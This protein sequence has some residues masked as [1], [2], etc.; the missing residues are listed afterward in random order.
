MRMRTGR[1]ALGDLPL[2][3]DPGRACALALPVPG[4][5]EAP[6]RFLAAVLAA[7][8]PEAG[9]PGVP[10]A[11][12]AGVGRLSN[13]TVCNPRDVC[14]WCLVRTAC[15][16]FVWRWDG[17]CGAQAEGPLA[18][19]I[20]LCSA[21]AAS[22]RAL[23][24]PSALRCRPMPAEDGGRAASFPKGIF[25]FV[26][27][28]LLRSW[29]A[30]CATETAVGCRLCSGGVRRKRAAVAAGPAALVILRSL[31]SRLTS[32]FLARVVQSA[33]SFPSLEGAVWAASE[34]P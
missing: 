12:E 6:E 30:C 8:G 34:A 14:C 17:D 21:I 25:N 33:A 16:D 4:L 19:F 26:K 13:S 31:K 18:S 32:R 20:A 28:D 5:W 11:L 15:L 27:G 22:T 29:G 24:A 10:A 9:L 3:A 1:G 7:A 23:R 2:S